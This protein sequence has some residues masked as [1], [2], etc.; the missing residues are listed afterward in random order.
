[1]LKILIMYVNVNK[2]QSKR[3]RMCRIYYYLLLPM[4]IQ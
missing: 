1:M 3:S 4:N 2:R